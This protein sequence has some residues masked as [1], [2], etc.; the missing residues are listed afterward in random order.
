MGQTGAAEF[1]LFDK[2][3]AKI[4]WPEFVLLWNDSTDPLVAM[5]SSDFAE[6]KKELEDLCTYYGHCEE[7][8]LTKMRA[9][10]DRVQHFANKMKVRSDQTNN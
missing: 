7:P 4:S 5:H 6:G 8:A 9:F 1:H 10:F 3:T 2:S